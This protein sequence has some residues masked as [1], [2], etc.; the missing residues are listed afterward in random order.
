MRL[1]R[2][3][4]FLAVGLLALPGC[5][6]FGSDPGSFDVSVTGDATASFSGEP[7]TIINPAGMSE[8]RYQFRLAAPGNDQIVSITAVSDGSAELAE[9]EYPVGRFGVDLGSGRAEAAVDMEGNQTFL[10]RSGS[11]T[12]TEVTDDRVRGSFE[13]EAVGDGDEVTVSGSFEA[14]L[15]ENTI[16]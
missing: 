15:D 4:L 11:L 10:S 5:D 13:F 1:V 12:L 7:V 14:D 2:S 16:S 6:V 3:V 8:R 9:G